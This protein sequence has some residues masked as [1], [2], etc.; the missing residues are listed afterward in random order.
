MTSSLIKNLL[1]EKQKEKVELAEAKTNRALRK[2]K[3]G[4][5]IKKEKLKDYC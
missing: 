1:E 4:A 2:I 3:M 5:K